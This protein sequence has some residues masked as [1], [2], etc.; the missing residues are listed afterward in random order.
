MGSWASRG[1]SLSPLPPVV[2]EL[3]P[4][5]RGEDRSNHPARPRPDHV[6]LAAAVRVARRAPEQSEVVDELLVPWFQV[7]LEANDVNVLATNR[8]RHA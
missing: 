3:Y 6:L 4:D 5:S 2:P 1:N 7:R 8:G